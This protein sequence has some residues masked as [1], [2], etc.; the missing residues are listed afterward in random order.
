MLVTPSGISISVTN[1]LFKYRFAPFDNG[2]ENDW[3]KCAQY[4]NERMQLV[5]NFLNILTN[6]SYEYIGLVT[7]ILYDEIS[8]NG[9]KKLSD[10]LLNSDKIHDLYD[11]IPNK[12]SN[13]STTDNYDIKGSCE[14]YKT[15]ETF[16]DVNAPMYRHNTGYKAVIEN[17]KIISLTAHY[18]RNDG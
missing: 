6:N 5:F 2:F 3:D 13:I 12:Y 14:E 11:I 7:N 17:D 8:S 18:Y 9:A 4:I 16:D 1:S 10:T 15:V